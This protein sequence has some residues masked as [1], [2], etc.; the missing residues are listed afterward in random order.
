MNEE[1][2]EIN[3]E[4]LNDS[5]QAEMQ[6]EQH[7]E[8]VVGSDSQPDEVAMLTDKY[9][10]LYADFENFR[11][12]SIKAR[13]ELLSV[14]SRDIMVKLLPVLDDF[15][16]AIKANENVDDPKALK[17]GFELIYS[18]FKRNLETEGLKS[19]ESTGHSFDTEFHDAV[20]KFPAPDESMKNKV[21]DTLEK[22]YT[23]NDR[24]IRY[25]KV[26]VGE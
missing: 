11:R 14:A 9:K 21:I 19:F 23:L 2:K 24:V 10:R 1:N 13:T 12:Q 5:N 4:N 8:S 22:G 20:T 17:E 26:V 6:Q 16:R 7:E 18:I 3:E 15:E 25:A